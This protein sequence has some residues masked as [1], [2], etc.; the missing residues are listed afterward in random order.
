MSSSSRK[1]EDKLLRGIGIT[2]AKAVH[3]NQPEEGPFPPFYD[4][5]SLEN[6]FFLSISEMWFLK[7]SY[8]NKG[9]T[10]LQLPAM[11]E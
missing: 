5:L 3:H 7:K 8:K 2:K 1:V 4:P 6:G 9:A 10:F 11:K